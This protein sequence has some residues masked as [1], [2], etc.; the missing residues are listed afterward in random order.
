MTLI[1]RQS[2]LRLFVGS[3]WQNFIGL[4]YADTQSALRG[5]FDELGWEYS[6]T[7][8]TSSLGDRIVLG[9]GETTTF[10]L[11]N[12]E[13]TVDCVSAAFDPVQRAIFGLTVRDET[14]AKYED[15]TT[16]IRISQIN[17]NTEPAIAT[18]VAALM[19]SIEKDP[20]EIVHPRFNLSPV[21]QYKTRVFWEYWQTDTPR[22]S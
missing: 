17:S 21:L 5:V 19:E 13:F 22:I 7:E 11:E 12:Q 14:K 9:G 4:S 3:K 20:W 6:V 2:L 1:S 10:E 18:F 8:T 15:A 16:V